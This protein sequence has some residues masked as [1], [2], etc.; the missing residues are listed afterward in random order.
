MALFQDLK[1]CILTC[2]KFD[3]KSSIALNMAEGKECSEV[4]AV[5][6]FSIFVVQPRKRRVSPLLYLNELV[7]P[8]LQWF[9]GQHCIRVGV[10]GS[11]LF[12]IE[13]LGLKK[14]WKVFPLLS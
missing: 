13:Q 11:S 7:A 9:L 6:S 2:R 4:A 14:V 5:R 1:L 12:R 8:S 10:Q 3:P